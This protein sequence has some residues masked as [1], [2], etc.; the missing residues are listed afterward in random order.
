MIRS[1]ASEHYL[2]C[3]STCA[4]HVYLTSVERDRQACALRHVSADDLATGVIDHDLIA[5]I[6]ILD[7]NLSIG[8]IDLGGVLKF[9][10]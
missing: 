9:Y 3:G 5:D 7:I 8:H 4:N 10:L 1:S 6:K 2:G